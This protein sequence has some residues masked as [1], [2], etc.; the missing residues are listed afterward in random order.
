MSNY[1]KVN[2]FAAKDAINAPVVGTE[3]QQEFDA[4]QT[5]VNS[6]ADSDDALLTGVPIAPTPDGGTTNQIVNVEYVTSGTA[7]IDA[8]SLR[9]RN[10]VTAKTG[11]ASATNVNNAGY[12][13]S[14]DNDSGLFNPEDGRVTVAINGTDR[15]SV[16]SEVRAVAPLVAQS[17][18]VVST[19]QVT[20]QGTGT[21]RVTGVDIVSASTDAANKSYVDGRVNPVESTLNGV[22]SLANATL[23]I[24]QVGSLVFALSDGSVNYGDTIGGNLLKPAS[25]NSGGTFDAGSRLSGTWRCLGQVNSPTNVTLFVRIS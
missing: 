12:V 24:N 14:G 11:N 1:N 19:G 22:S 5:A 9:S 21:G 8:Q 15:L 20:L 4:V 3:F 23:N 16:T 10:Q 2:D 25:V 6:K 7:P 13:F 18:L 17:G